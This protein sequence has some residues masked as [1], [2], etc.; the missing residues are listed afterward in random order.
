[1]GWDALA[2]NLTVLDV[3]GGHSSM[4]QEAFVQSLAEALMPY[5]SG[6]RVTARRAFD[7]ANQGGTDQIIPKD[8]AMADKS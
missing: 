3:E 4:L 1:L 2:Q 8:L 6:E 5:L 7:T